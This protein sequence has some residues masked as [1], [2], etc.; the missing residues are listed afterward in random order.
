MNGAQNKKNA[1]RNWKYIL[2]AVILA[3]IVCGGI[4]CYFWNKEKTVPA[5]PVSITPAAPISIP[6]TIT[7]SI[8]PVPT[9]PPEVWKTYTSAELGFSIKYPEMVYGLY[10]CS[11][12][13]PFWVPLKVFEDKENGIVYITQE[14]YYDDWNS[15]TQINTGICEKITY[16]LG[17]LQNE[18]RENVSWD[19]SYFLQAEKTYL[20]WGILVKN[21]KNETELNKFINDNY[22]SDCFISDKLSWKKSGIYEINIGGKYNEEGI[23][24]KC[25]LHYAYKVLYAPKKNKLVSIKLGQECTFATITDPKRP[26]WSYKCYEEEMLDSFEF[27]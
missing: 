2:I 7:P 6:T 15:E 16:Y 20:G 23:N 13:K 14:Y 26:S 22:G 1:L 24:P 9:P 3:F 10:K 25:P 18:W 11:N 21:I 19:D 17:L 4:L 8:T 12:D 27:K 5:P